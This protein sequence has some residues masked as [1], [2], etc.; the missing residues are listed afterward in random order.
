MQLIGKGSFTKAYLVSP[1]E[2]M[3]DTRD[4]VKHHIVNGDVIQGSMFPK[5]YKKA[6]GRIYSK[7]LPRT[8]SLKANLSERHWKYYK[9]LRDLSNFIE[10]DCHSTV[11][12]RRMLGTIKYSVLHDQVV[13]QFEQLRNLAPY[14]IYFECSPRNVRAHKGK[15]VLLDCFFYYSELN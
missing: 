2:V 3:L 1:G 10:A 12:I 11:S 5:L 7:Y 6:D 14:D 4:P 13:N 9:E 15:L 8:P